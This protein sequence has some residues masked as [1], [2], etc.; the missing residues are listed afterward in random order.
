MAQVVRA[1]LKTPAGEDGGA[2]KRG[3]HWDIVKPLRTR[4]DV[5]KRSAISSRR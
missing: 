2:E 1:V 3:D 5:I 4:A